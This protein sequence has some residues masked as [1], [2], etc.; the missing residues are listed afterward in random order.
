MLQSA[1][2]LGMLNSD[3]T[4]G[5]AARG[6]GG[7]ELFFPLIDARLSSVPRANVGATASAPV[8]KTET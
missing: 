2:N 8:K 7:I 6:E 1:T 4:R 3:S 5:E